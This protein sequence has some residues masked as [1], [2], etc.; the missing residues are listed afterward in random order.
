MDDLETIL[1]RHLP[2]F[3]AGV[4][5]AMAPK[6]TLPEHWTSASRRLFD[7]MRLRS[8]PDRA[9]YNTPVEW[10]EHVRTLARIANHELGL[11][12]PDSE[13]VAAARRHADWAWETLAHF[14]LYLHDPER[15]ARRGV[16]SGRSR[17]LRVRGRDQLILKFLHRFPGTTF[18][19]L[20]AVIGI[21][22][23]TV[24]RVVEREA[25][26]F[27]AEIRARFTCAAA[28]H[29]HAA[30]SS[31]LARHRHKFREL[32]RQVARWTKRRREQAAAQAATEAEQA[33]AE[34]ALAAAVA[35]R[36]QAEAGTLA[37]MTPQ[38]KNRQRRQARELPEFL[39]V[40]NEALASIAPAEAGPAS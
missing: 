34:A 37:A 17:R 1:G 29:G 33:R 26:E 12:L 21:H 19:A 3:T 4:A 2:E 6:T 36:R 39:R 8:Y 38:E 15:Q 11:P 35:A 31:T 16:A 9:T 30:S 32:A 22:A 20:A 25:P 23:T 28:R 27:L 40:C 13:V 18:T 10:Q 14:V 24:M 7:L 5:A